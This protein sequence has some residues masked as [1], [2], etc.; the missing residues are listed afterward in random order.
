MIIQCIVNSFREQ[1]LKGQHDLLTDT[2]KW[3]AE[4]LA[5]HSYQ[6][7]RDP[8]AVTVNVDNRSVTVDARALD[9]SQRGQLR[10]LLLQA[11]DSQGSGSGD[12]TEDSEE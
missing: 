1:M 3:Y 2:L 4:R 11:R 6:E 9:A 8:Q 10:T 5:P 7:R 12:M